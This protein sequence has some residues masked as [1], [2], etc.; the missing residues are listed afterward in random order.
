MFVNNSFAALPFVTDDAMIQNLNQL[1]IETFTENW[2]I[3]AEGNVQ[4]E[5]SELYGQYLSF[6]YGLF[7]HFEITTGGMVGYDAKEKSTAFSNLIFQ[8]KTK[9]FEG[10]KPILPS[11]ALDL[12]YVHNSGSGQYYDPATNF[13]AIIA[14]THRMLNDSFIIH[15]N[16]GDK[17]SYQIPTGNMHRLHLG[18]GF[19]IAIPIDGVRMIVESYNGSPNSPRDSQGYFHSY[20]VGCKFAKS[21]TLSFHVLYGSQP[22]LIRYNANNDM[23][24]RRT[25]WVQFGIR[26]VINNLL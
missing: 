25:N 20:Q 2:R 10:N 13:Y 16:I 21:D 7:K 14:T 15:I 23:V 17:A 6:S 19:D 4:K 8:L 12:G 5:K 18:I 24:F 1:G 11:V 3:P 9:L 22:T 26:K